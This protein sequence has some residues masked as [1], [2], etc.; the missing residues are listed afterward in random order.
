MQFERKI[1][2]AALLTP[3]FVLLA[4]AAAMAIDTSDAAVLNNQGVEFYQRGNYSAAANKFESAILVDP[5]NVDLYLNL[6]YTQ[7]AEGNHSAA[8]DSFKKVLSLDPS[9]LDAHN[10]L[11]VS[12][13]QS[14]DI[15][16]AAAEWELVLMMD[17]TNVTAAANLGIVHNPE[18][19]DEIIAE[20]RKAL[21]TKS[22]NPQDPEYTTMMFDEGKSAFKDGAFDEAAKS[23]QQ[24]LEIKP[25]SKF[26]YYY[27]GISLAYLGQTAEGVR[28]LREYLILES[29]PPESRET[30]DSAMHTF[31]LIRAG[32]PLPRR[33]DR[34]DREAEGAYEDGK[35]AF[36]SG[37]YFKAIHLMKTAYGLRPDSFSV[38]Y[39]LGLSY[40]AVGDKERATFHLA[41]CLMQSLAQGR[42]E[43]ANEIARILRDLTK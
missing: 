12:L 8:I 27:L 3:L 10:S 36:K 35:T 42:K 9:N 15:D 25:S 2:N 19:A 7:Q 4:C 16:R 31:N 11:G 14:G 26:S 30:Y 5:Q 43:E 21:S 22:P 24:I 28:N 34:Q 41:K 32:K 20:T 18:R 33:P 39:Y 6:A 17:P 38:N 29:Y 40:R 13:Y 37:D 1:V 23:F